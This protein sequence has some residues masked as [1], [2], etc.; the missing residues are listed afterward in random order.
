LRYGWG[1]CLSHK[2][3]CLREEIPYAQ[4]KMEEIDSTIAEYKAK[5]HNLKLQKASIQEREIESY[6][7][8]DFPCHK[9][10]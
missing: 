7:E 9:E 4:Q 10:S 1:H 6:E 3:D 8:R 5:I 2:I